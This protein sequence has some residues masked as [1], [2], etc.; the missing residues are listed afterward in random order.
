M[1]YVWRLPTKVTRPVK[2]TMVTTQGASPRPIDSRFYSCQQRLKQ[3]SIYDHIIAILHF[4]LFLSQGEV[5][6][7]DP[8]HDKFERSAVNMP[9]EEISA[10]SGEPAFLNCLS[11]DRL[12]ICTCT[13]SSSAGKC[14]PLP[15]KTFLT[16]Y[17]RRKYSYILQETYI[18]DQSIILCRD[19]SLSHC[20]A[21]YTFYEIYI[22]RHA[23]RF[24]FDFILYEQLG[25]IGKTFGTFVCM[26]SDQLHFHISITQNGSQSLVGLITS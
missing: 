19:W 26:H 3:L 5:C 11:Q 25:Y 8:T 18:L 23:G 13:I 6:D 4:N 21:P 24:I 15:C 10:D 20:A 17:L 7:D 16:K 14:S 1:S 12:Q 22:Q 2:Y 9:V